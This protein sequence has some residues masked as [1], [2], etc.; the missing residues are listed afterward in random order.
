MTRCIRIFG[1]NPVAQVEDTLTAERQA[2]VTT[3]V[4]RI[5]FV[6]FGVNVELDTTSTLRTPIK[7]LSPFEQLSR[8][9]LCQQKCSCMPIVWLC[10]DDWRHSSVLQSRYI[11]VAKLGNSGSRMYHWYLLHVL[12]PLICVDADNPCRFEELPEVN[13]N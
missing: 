11:L 13:G 4:I 12:S 10:P 8:N 2:R 3:G 1:V 9:K 6:Y 7:T 5:S